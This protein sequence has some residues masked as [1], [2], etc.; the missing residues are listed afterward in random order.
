[1]LP[2]E[3]YTEVSGFEARKVSLNQDP[4]DGYYKLTI[5]IDPTLAPRWLLDASAGQTLAVGIKALDHDNPETP[6][7]PDIVKRAALLCKNVHF[8]R[9][10]TKRL[11]TTFDSFEPAD[12]TAAEAICLYCNI[13]SRAELRNNNEAYSIFERLV[14]EFNESARKMTFK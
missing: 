4:K 11:G 2:K 1:M 6:S 8:Q 14:E 5:K 9:F 13:S 12:K 3:A 10:L 7:G